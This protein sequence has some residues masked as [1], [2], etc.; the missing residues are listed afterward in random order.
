MSNIDTESNTLEC[1]IYDNTDENMKKLADKV[2]DGELVIFPTETVYG[3]GANIFNEKAINDIFAIKNRPKNNP[4]IV[5]CLGYYDSKSLTNLNEMDDYWFKLLADN[6]WPGP[7]T[8]VV[9]ASKIVASNV[10]CN[11]GYVGLRSPKHNAIR[12][13]I[14][15]AQT[16]IA[17]PSANISGKVSSTCLDHVKKYFE[18]CKINII[19]DNDYIS[20][21]GIESTVVKLENS[22]LSI[23]RQGFITEYDIKLFYNKYCKSHYLKILHK[24]NVT[25]NISPGQLK[26]HYCPNKP[27]YIL[28]LI[29]YPDDTEFQKNKEEICS[30]TNNYLKNSILIDFNSICFEYKDKFLGYVDLSS[31]GD[32]KEAMFNLYNVFHQL[33]DINCD[34][35]LIYNFGNI[36]NIYTESI[37]D[38]ITRASI[39][40]IYIPINFF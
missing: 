10:N 21:F 28:N 37:W 20:E 3:I 6:F 31:N 19:N 36:E 22:E 13:I 26:S 39:N 38:K 33:N 17:A 7:L 1:K 5:H 23:L 35:I 29:S 18:S 27:L 15:Y 34:K 32:F 12:S 40:N 14:Q 16:P 2:L 30:V 24:T 25:D 8:I 11:N 4:L 9:K